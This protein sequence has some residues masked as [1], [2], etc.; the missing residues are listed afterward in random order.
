M[1]VFVYRSSK[2]EGLFVFVLDEERISTLPAPL[3]HQLGDPSLALT[4]DLHADRK[5][6]TE[7]ATEVITNLENNGY[8]VQMP[9]DIETIIAAISES[10]QSQD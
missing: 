2:K 10:T 3:V 7:D 8:H 6:G 1:K 5:L 4:F 9:K